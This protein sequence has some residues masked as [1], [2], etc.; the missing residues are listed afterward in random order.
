MS[1]VRY[2]NLL[3][4]QNSSTGLEIIGEDATITDF[5]TNS[6]EDGLTAEE[7]NTY[8]TL[9]GS[10]LVLKSNITF[11]SQLPPGTRFTNLETLDV[12][13][14]TNISQIPTTYNSG[15][16]TLKVSSTKVSSIPSVYSSITMLEIN[17]CKRLASIGIPTLETLVMSH[18]SVTELTDLISLVRLVCLTSKLTNIPAAPNLVVVTW[19]GVSSSSALTVDSSNSNISQILTTGPTSNITSSNGVIT[20]IVF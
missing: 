17:N 9:L 3:M 19:S 6:A 8:T 12:N 11:L 18:S 15:L 10:I 13:N 5:S 16:S 7:L 2:Y 20:S 14:C 4:F 1:L